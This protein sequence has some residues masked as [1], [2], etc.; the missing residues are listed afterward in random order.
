MTGGPGVRDASHTVRHDDRAKPRDPFAGLGE[1]ERRAALA[2]VSEN[3]TEVR[4]SVFGQRILYWSLG[5]AFIVGLFADIGGFL[6]K[7]STTTEPL[8]L[9]GDLLYTLG[10][11]LWTAAV[12]VVFLQIIPEAKRRQYKAALDAYEAALRDEADAES[13]EVQL[14]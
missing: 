9:I 13:R 5:T 6:I 12:V 7:S 1:R 2:W 4:Q 10:W 8:G 3:L 11:A 14:D